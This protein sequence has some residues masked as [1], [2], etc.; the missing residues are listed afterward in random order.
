MGHNK[1]E[2]WNSDVGVC[3]Q[4]QN[5]LNISLNNIKNHK[6]IEPWRKDSNPRALVWTLLEPSEYYI[7]L[8]DAVCP[9]KEIKCITYTDLNKRYRLYFI[10][11]TFTAKKKDQTTQNV[12][13]NLTNYKLEYAFKKR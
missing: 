9:Q 6:N 13:P 10:V 2:G 7:Y 8:R 5:M 4:I 1:G 11:H 12:F 3:K